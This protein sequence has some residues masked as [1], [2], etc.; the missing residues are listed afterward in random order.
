MSKKYCII[1]QRGEKIEQHFLFYFM[2]YLKFSK[3][4]NTCIVSTWYH[5]IASLFHM[6]ANKISM[7]HM[8]EYDIFIFAQ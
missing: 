8:R 1:F 7:M 4:W 6:I 2:I 3:S 5:V